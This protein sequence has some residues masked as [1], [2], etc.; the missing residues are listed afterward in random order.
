[1][2][3]NISRRDFMKKGTIAAGFCMIGTLSNRILSAEKGN[4]KV[5]FKPI[6]EGGKGCHRCLNSVK[7][8]LKNPEMR[9]KLEKLLPENSE[10]YF[11]VKVHTS[12]TKIPNQAVGICVGECTKSLKNKAKVFVKGC[13]K[14]IDTEY[15]F[16][17][18]VKQLSKQK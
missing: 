10:V 15:V 4:K 3:N 17:S 7:A 1:M 8:I 16:N 14:E 18:I 12:N 9:Q 13:T 5:T 11:Y 6:K 2:Q